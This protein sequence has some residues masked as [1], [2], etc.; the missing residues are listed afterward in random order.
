[1]LQIAQEVTS[2]E[3]QAIASHINSADNKNISHCPDVY[4]QH[5][6]YITAHLL[7]HIS[8]YMHYFKTDTMDGTSKD[9]ATYMPGRCN[10]DML[11]RSIKELKNLRVIT[12][13]TL[14]KNKIRQR[15]ITFNVQRFWELFGPI[16]VN[17][18][19]KIIAK[20]QIKERIQINKEAANTVVK[21]AAKGKR[22]DNL[23]RWHEQKVSKKLTVDVRSSMGV[24]RKSAGPVNTLNTIPRPINKYSSNTRDSDQNLDSSYPQKLASWELPLDDLES[25]QVCCPKFT[26]KMI[27]ERIGLW[28]ANVL[29]KPVMQQPECYEWVDECQRYC[30]NGYEMFISSANYPRHTRPGNVI[31]IKHATASHPNQHAF[32]SPDENVPPR[33]AEESRTDL[34]KREP[35]LEEISIKAEYERSQTETIHF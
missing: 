21:I 30:R 3:Q 9:L 13:T 12:T 19:P 1:M 4:H 24:S 11:D 16:Y 27:T 33:V 2:P 10:A 34:W 6:T 25:L 29:A 14:Y 31:K 15:V 32:L 17:L 20:Q 23:D 8:D 22:T 5:C 35:T 18:H 28:K 26:N 7:H